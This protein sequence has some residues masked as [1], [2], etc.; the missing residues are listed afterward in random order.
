[1]STVMLAVTALI[2]I[3]ASDVLFLTGTLLFIEFT[4][5]QGQYSAEL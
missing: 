2:L 3:I 4:K 1:L 5:N